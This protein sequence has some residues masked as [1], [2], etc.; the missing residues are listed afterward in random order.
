MN[1]VGGKLNPYLSDFGINTVVKGNGAR[2]ITIWSERTAMSAADRSITKGL[3]RIKEVASCLSLKEATITKACD[4]YKKIA[5]SGELKG[6]SIDSRVAT[7]IFMASR[8]VGQPKPIKKILTFSDVTEKDLSKTYKK[9]K[10]L[11]PEY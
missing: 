11:F 2:E 6:K 7:C 5:D 10:L 3:R 8:I 1:R 4:L 9:V